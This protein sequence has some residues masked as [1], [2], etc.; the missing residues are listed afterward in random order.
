MRIAALITVA[1][2]LMSLEPVEAQITS[3]PFD[4]L[5]SNLVRVAAKEVQAIRNDEALAKASSLVSAAEAIPSEF[6]APEHITNPAMRRLHGLQPLLAGIFRDEG[7]PVELL[8]VGLV[9]SGYQQDA[10]SPAEAVGMWQFVPSTARRFGLINE[11][12]DFRTDV[13]RSTRAAARYLRFLLDEFQD[14]RL[15][16]A[17][18]N[19]GEDRVEE[20]M[21]KAQSRD[22]SKLSSLRL[23]PEE[24]LK[25]VPA[26]LGAI[27]EA[28][29]HGLLDRIQFGQGGAYE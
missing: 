22:F 27:A 28:R 5:H 1:L 26:V 20:A 24:T 19:A 8:L 12:G 29:N 4:A 16:L 21:R 25:Y 10:V 9:E 11:N 13:V 14:W 2:F 7:V 17:A 18:Y 6:A 23:L 3:D 15:A